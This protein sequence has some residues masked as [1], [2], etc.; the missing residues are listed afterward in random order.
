MTYTYAILDV[1]ES[2]YQEIYSKLGKAQYFHLF[3]DHDS[4]IDMHSIAL[5]SDSVPEELEKTGIPADT[6]RM[7]KWFS[8]DHLPEPLYETSRHFYQVATYICEYV[9]RGPE[10]TV[11]LRKLLEA[12]EAAVRATLHPGG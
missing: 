4:I 7:L 5:R 8:Y 9:Q 10:R 2:A 11:T 3:H 1:S 6:E 12:K